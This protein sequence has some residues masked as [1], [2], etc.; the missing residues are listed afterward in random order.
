M[1]NCNTVLRTHKYLEQQLN[2]FKT[3]LVP[4]FQLYLRDDPVSLEE[5]G[6]NFGEPIVQGLETL[7]GLCHAG[8][9][10]AN[11]LLNQWRFFGEKVHVI[12]EVKDGRLEL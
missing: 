4:L 10:L 5:I 7:L 6:F 11:E 12:H 3:S 1:I 2:D 9:V 8:V